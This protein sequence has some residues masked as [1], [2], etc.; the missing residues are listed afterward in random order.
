MAATEPYDPWDADLERWL[1]ED[2][3][4]AYE[5]YLLSPEDAR[6]IEEAFARI[7]AFMAELERGSGSGTPP[8]AGRL[9]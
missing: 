7:D 8:D 6:P 1:R 5:A 3:V 4:A 9:E 2:V